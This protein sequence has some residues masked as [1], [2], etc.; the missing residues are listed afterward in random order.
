[1]L[2]DNLQADVKHQLEIWKGAYDNIDNK[3]KELLALDARRAVI[4]QEIE[5]EQKISG[6]A[7]RMLNGL[8]Q[9]VDET[10]ENIKAIQDL[11]GPFI[12]D[13]AMKQVVE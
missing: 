11:I 10:D 12:S 9:D 4:E 3:N 2:S 6:D 8:L 7:K 1:M 13:I 5:A